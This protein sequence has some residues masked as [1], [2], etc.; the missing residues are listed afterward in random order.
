MDFQSS[1]SIYHGLH[2]IRLS[3]FCFEYAALSWHVNKV[4]VFGFFGFT[5]GVTSCNAY[6]AVAVQWASLL[7]G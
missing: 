3:M 5:K 2:G 4:D 6:R 1:W 7:Q